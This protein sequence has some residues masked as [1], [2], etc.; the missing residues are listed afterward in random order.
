MF[1]VMTITICLLYMINFMM[2]VDSLILINTFIWLLI[3]AISW[4]FVLYKK[5][6]TM[7]WQ[8]HF[9]LCIYEN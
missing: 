2:K 6:M 4:K 3:L 8:K 1:I 5:S 7:Y 9:I